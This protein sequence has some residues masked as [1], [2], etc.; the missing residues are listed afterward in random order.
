MSTT[1]L[2]MD[3]SGG[4]REMV[5]FGSVMTMRARTARWSVADAKARLSQVIDQARER[6]QTIERRGLPVAVVVSVEQFDEHDDVARWRHFLDLSAEIRATGGGE[7][8]LPR[9]ASRRSPLPSR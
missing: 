7:I 8:R 3:R 5:M 4:L 1:G 6:P 2:G 9:R